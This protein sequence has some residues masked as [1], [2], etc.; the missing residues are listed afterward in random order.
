MKKYCL[1]K[2][3]ALNALMAL[4]MTGSAYAVDFTV[5][6]GEERNDVAEINVGTDKFK[7]LIVK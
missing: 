3:L 6:A 5:N 2:T 4:V 1:K 7:R